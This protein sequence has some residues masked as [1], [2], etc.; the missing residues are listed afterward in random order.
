MTTGLPAAARPGQ[1]SSLSDG[2]VHAAELVGQRV[3][4]GSPVPDAMQE[5]ARQALFE[6]QLARE[7]LAA[8]I[9]GRLHAPEPGS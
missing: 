6:F 8:D 7:A 2:L 4:N 3:G 9:K 5:Q 1:A